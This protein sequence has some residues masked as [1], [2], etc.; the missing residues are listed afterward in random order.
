MDD[1]VL[2]VDP[3]SL[4]PSE[5]LSSLVVRSEAEDDDDDGGG[6]FLDA[7]A[8]SKTRPYRGSLSGLL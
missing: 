5:S 2:M 1:D 8:F 7:T 6:Q 4:F 3:S